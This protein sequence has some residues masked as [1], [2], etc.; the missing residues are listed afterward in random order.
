MAEHRKFIRQSPSTAE[1]YIGLE[2]EIIVELET[3][4]IRVHDGIT[5]GGYATLTLAS[6]LA[7]FVTLTDFNAAIAQLIVDV[8]TINDDA[9]TTI[10]GDILIAKGPVADI[11]TG[12]PGSPADGDRYLIAAGGTSGVFIGKENQVVERVDGD[13]Q[14]SGS[15]SEGH[16]V[17]VQDVDTV[18]YYTGSAWSTTNPDATYST[19]QTAIDDAI[20]LKADLASPTFTGVPAAPTAAPGTDTTQLA[21]TAFVQ[22]AIVAQGLGGTV[23]TEGSQSLGD[24]IIKWGLYGGGSANPTINFAASFPNAC[25]NVQC[26]PVNISSDTPDEASTRNVKSI[27]LQSLSASG[28]SAFCSYEDGVTDVMKADNAATFYWTAIG[29]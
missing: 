7:Q 12:P 21:T 20:D 8:T 3:F 28:F 9:I 22:A 5:P 6:A 23:G 10:L 2:G 29:R 14:F 17:Y 16:Q 27:G 11:L 13:W 15:P 19:R 26:T 18:H 4:L 1:A 25:Y 24:I